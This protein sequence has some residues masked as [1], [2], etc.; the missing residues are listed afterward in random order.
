[1]SW[2]WWTWFGIAVVLA[3]LVSFAA[4]V[5]RT[6]RIRRYERQ[7]LENIRKRYKP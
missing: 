3:L 7:T 6:Y 1:M 4:R 2:E 5:V